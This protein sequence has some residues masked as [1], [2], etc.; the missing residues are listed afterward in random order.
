LKTARTRTGR[1]HKRRPATTI[2]FWLSG[3]ARV[4]FL[5]QS[6]GPDCSPAG[7]FTVRGRS[8]RNEIRFTGKVRDGRLQPG[9]Y[10]ITPIRIRGAQPSGRHAVGVEVLPSGSV[11][12]RITTPCELSAGPS[13]TASSLGGRQAVAGTGPKSSSSKQASTSK[14]KKKGRLQGVLGAFRPPDLSLPGETGSFPWLLGVAA[15]AL[16]ALSA[17][18]I[19][20]YVLTYVRR[21]RTL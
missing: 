3:P 11:P 8:G 4:V 17:G 19:L 2:T 15:L 5:V 10:R 6:G 13:T 9:R 21:A 16:L 20:A 12:T 1:G 7:R 14:P 18:A